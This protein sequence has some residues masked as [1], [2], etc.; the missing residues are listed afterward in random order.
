MESLPKQNITESIVYETF[1]DESQLEPLMKMI[2][3]ELSEPYSIYTYRYF[4]VNWPHLTFL[5]LHE[6]RIIGVNIGKL[7]R[8]K[9]AENKM[10]GYIAMIV[11]LKEYRGHG[12]GISL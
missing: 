2:E 1:R 5:A 7:E 8:H 11:V 4:V 12:L 3:T 9:G 10:R 6:G